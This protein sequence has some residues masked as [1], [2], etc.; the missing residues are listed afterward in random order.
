MATTESWDHIV[1]Q[2]FDAA[3]PAFPAFPAQL[4]LKQRT[5]YADG[6]C[7]AACSMRF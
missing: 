4:L 1:L 6:I 3:F 5:R 2:W 7:T